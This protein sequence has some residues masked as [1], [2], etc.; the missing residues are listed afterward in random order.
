MAIN[1]IFRLNTNCYIERRKTKKND[2]ILLAN[3]KNCSP[4]LAIIGLSIEF[5]VLFKLDI[6]KEM[7]LFIE[8]LEELKPILMSSKK[9][10]K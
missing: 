9:Q 6:P 8:G 3:Y 5:I 10:M 7:A 1:N 4:H 2:R